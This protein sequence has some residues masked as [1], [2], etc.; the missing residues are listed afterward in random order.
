MQSK[1]HITGGASTIVTNNLTTSKALTSN[2]SGKVM[3]SAIS[4]V[5]LGIFRWSNFKHSDT[6]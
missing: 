3:A 6:A 1:L 2:S 4:S 5:E